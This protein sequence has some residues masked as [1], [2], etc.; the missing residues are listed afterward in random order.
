[1]SCPTSVT[2]VKPL[3]HIRCERWLPVPGEVVVQ[4]G[5]AV[6]P[7]Q[8]VARA[9]IPRGFLIL[10]AS[11]ALKVPP[12]EVARYLLVE[13]GVAVRQ[14]QPLLRRPGFL[15]GRRLLASPIDGIFH[16]ARHGRLILQKMPDTWELR[17]MVQGTVVK[18]AAE[19]QVVIET[20]GALIQAAWNSGKEGFGKVKVAT[21]GPDGV[22][23]AAQI[24]PEARGAI[25]VAGRV[26]ELA[27]LRKAEE[28]SAR[29]LIVGSLPADLFTAAP[30]IAF[31]IVL[32]E[33]VGTTQMAEP[34][35]RLLKQ[36]HG[37]EATLLPPAAGGRPSI[38]IPLTEAMDA[39]GFYEN[40]PEL[41][42]GLMARI[43][44]PPYASQVGRIVA[45][46]PR[47]VAMAAGG[48]APAAEVALADGQAVF[49]PY[50]NLDLLV[51]AEA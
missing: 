41:A 25:L 19:Q 30:Q 31:P 21:G 20:K 4:V 11:E 28:N 39:D 32:T 27:A 5:Q 44:R 48:R 16:Q 15:G 23:T 38:I 45:L 40:P 46:R 42:I 7:V 37:D 17:A 6:A 36:R 9:P 8:V 22:L 29:G 35:F 49:V 34:I 3:A 14:G 13:E 47:G 2:V 1:M 18:V 12:A 24:G 33:G 26:D 10:R 50:V 43:L 51:G